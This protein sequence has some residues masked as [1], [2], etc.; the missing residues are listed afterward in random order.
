M[1]GLFVSNTSYSGEYLDLSSGTYY[2]KNRIYQP[3]TGRFLTEDPIRDG[4][5]YYTYCKNNP[6]FYWDPFG[7][8]AIPLRQWFDDQLKYNKNTYSNASGVLDW[9]GDTKTASVLM[10]SNGYGGYAEFKPGV[11]G[12]Y[13]DPK[14]N[15]MYVE[16]D[17]LWQAFGKSI[18]PPLEVHPV[19]DT[20][21]IA[22]T[23]VFT[24]KAP[25][26]ISGV[27]NVATKIAPI[28]TGAGI[29]TVNKALDAGVNFTN[30]TL[31]RMQ[32]PARFVPI[33]TL[34]DAIKYGV[35]KPDP[36]GSQAIM[37]T[38]EMFKN[39]KAYQLEVLYDEATNTIFHFLY[40]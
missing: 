40:K 32:N 33:S 17:L 6:I 1:L 4:L 29:A 31:Q 5:N 14:T 24:V 18:D 10:M 19:R 7:L 36:Q 15:R 26:I 22:A 35:A 12:T 28:I 37:Y 13:I 27:E 38:I 3:S 11:D 9:N 21:V 2:L 23:I 34:T 39:G 30:T 25:S 16:K 20:A 8:E